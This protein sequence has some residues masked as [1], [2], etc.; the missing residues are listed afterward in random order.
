MAT[1]TISMNAAFPS[2]Q[3][4]AVPYG[5]RLASLPILLLNVHEDDNCRSMKFD[6]WPREEGKELDLVDFQRQRDSIEALGV[7]HIV[8]T[9]GEP[10]L[11]RNFE[12][13]CRGLKECGVRI[14]L[15]TTGL[16]LAKRAEVIAEYLDEVIVSL[17]GPEE[18]HD[19]VRR[20]K[21]A[22][23]LIR[24]GVV[25][26][27]RLA[28][29][30]PIR[31]R[32]TVQKANHPLLRQ[33]VAGAKELGLSS[34]SFLAADMSSQALH[35]ELTWPGERQNQISLLPDE[36]R[37]LEEEIT[38]L[39]EE[40]AEDLESMYIVESAGELLRIVRR[41]KEQLG[42]MAPVAPRCN[43]PW[44]SAVMEVDGSVRPCFFH[45]SIG[46]V[47]EQTLAE[48]INGDEAVRFRASLHVSENPICKRC[49]CALIYRQSE[50]SL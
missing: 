39:I 31:G 10:L 9:G 29:A 27:R 32:S 42:R 50:V 34:I 17:D 5:P 21:G 37:A 11:H 25:A 12:G 8:L 3:Y 49:V 18:V 4:D 24:E 13:L 44:V 26:V 35:R 1:E 14:T 7:E 48:A 15:L 38:A 45:P 33:T 28:P 46:N 6:L 16:L 36:I 19:Q 41:F 40:N 20:V 23:R 47:G 22:F 2:L 30:L 43:A